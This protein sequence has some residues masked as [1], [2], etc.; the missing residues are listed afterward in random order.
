MLSFK[1][2]MSREIFIK[3]VIYCRVIINDYRIEAIITYLN[4]VKGVK[5]EKVIF[6]NFMRK[7]SII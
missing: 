2:I 5:N 1:T 4:T 7:L 3:I 6:S